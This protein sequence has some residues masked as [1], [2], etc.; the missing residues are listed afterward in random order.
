MGGAGTRQGKNSIPHPT[1]NPHLIFIPALLRERPCLS[2]PG[3][4]FVPSL[5]PSLVT[6]VFSLSLWSTCG[7]QSWKL[8]LPA[9]LNMH[10]GRDPVWMCSECQ[11]P[12]RSS[13]S[14][15]CFVEPV[16]TILVSAQLQA[17]SQPPS[18]LVLLLPQLSILRAPGFA[19]DVPEAWNALINSQPA[20]TVHCGQSW[21]GPHACTA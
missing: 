21:P 1:L 8:S 11:C 12:A 17:K 10:Q 9:L 16:T 3:P 4:L 13:S 5:I 20:L 7:V 18:S 6:P 15:P 14:C 19:Q 2:S